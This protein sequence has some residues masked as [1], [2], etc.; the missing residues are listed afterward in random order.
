[1]TEAG[2]AAATEETPLLGR[3]PEGVEQTGGRR[4]QHGDVRG[5]RER[6]QGLVRRHRGGVGRMAERHRRVE[7][8]GGRWDGRAGGGLVEDDIAGALGREAQPP[9]HLDAALGHHRDAADGAPEVDHR[10]GRAPGALEAPLVPE[11]VGG[12]AGQVGDPR[13]LPGGDVDEVVLP[14]ELNGPQRLGG[15]RLD[16]PLPEDL[17]DAAQ[18]QEVGRRH[19]DRAGR[20]LL[21]GQSEEP[22]DVVLVHQLVADVDAL[23]PHDGRGGEDVD[24]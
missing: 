18:L 3:R 4:P 8:A 11:A 14:H 15:G 16:V 22:A 2:R 21:A 6:R 20:A 1:M 24:Q 13:R 12:H 5:Q 10:L 7:L 23:D 9:R 17:G 19:V